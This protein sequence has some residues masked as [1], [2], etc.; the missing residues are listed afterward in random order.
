MAPLVKVLAK[1]AQ[2]PEFGL[3][4]STHTQKKFRAMMLAWNPSTEEV[5]DRRVSGAC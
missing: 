2:G 5:K 4:A 1:Q 3:L